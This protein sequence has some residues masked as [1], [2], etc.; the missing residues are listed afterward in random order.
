MATASTITWKSSNPGDGAALNAD[1]YG[2]Y[3]R[4]EPW[5]GYQW[6]TNDPALILDLVRLEEPC[7]QRRLLEL[8]QSLWAYQD[9]TILIAVNPN[10]PGERSPMWWKC[11]GKWDF[12]IEHLQE[13]WHGGRARTPTPTSK[14]PPSGG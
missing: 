8:Q 10:L 3:E 11:C 12:N 14:Q 6:G 4:E 1:L 5:L 9:A 7:V 2:A 13:R